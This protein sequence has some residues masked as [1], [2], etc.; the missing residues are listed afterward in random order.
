MSWTSVDQSDGAHVDLLQT[1]LDETSAGVHVVVGELL[2]DLGQAQA[3]GDEFVGIDAHLVFARGTAEAGH[4][5]N[6]RHC[7]KV[8]F[9]DPVFDGLQFH[10]VIGGLVLCKV[11]K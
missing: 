10:R 8:L 6:V 7:F 9:D 1:L 3:I 4:V 11:K 5:D 2:L